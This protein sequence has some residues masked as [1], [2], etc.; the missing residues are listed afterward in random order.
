MDA[1]LGRAGGVSLFGCSQQRASRI[2]VKTIPLNNPGPVHV[3]SVAGAPARSARTYI[4]RTGHVMSTNKRCIHLAARKIGRTRGLV[5]VGVNL[6]DANCVIPLITSM[7]FG[8]GMTSMTTRCTR[9]IHVGPNGCMS[10]KHAFGRLRCASRRCTTRLRGVHSHF[11]PF[12]GVY[13]RGRAT[14]HVKIGRNSL[15][16]HVVSHCNSAPRNVMRSYVRFLHVYMSRGFASIIVSVGTSGAIMV[17]GAMHLLMSIVRRRNVSFPLRLNIARTN[18]K[19]SKHVGSTLNVNTLLTSKLNSAVH[20]SLDRRPRTRVPITQGL[21]SCVADHQGRPCVPNVRTPSFGCLSPM[22]H[23]AQPMRGV[24]KSRLPIMLT[25]HVSKH[26][27]ARPRFAPSCVCTKHTLPRR[28]RPKIR[29]V[30]S[31][32]M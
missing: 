1:D 18:S 5:G 23:G 26:V 22:H 13:G 6:H 20:I 30:L 11:I 15:S 2:G 29:C 9:G 25:S 14:I 10:P 8:P 19:R 17:M 24:N 7:R 16:S 4:T 12:L 21:I 27:R 28:A 31:T 32:S 3:R